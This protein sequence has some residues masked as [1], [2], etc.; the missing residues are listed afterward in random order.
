MHV[1]GTRMHVAGARHAPVTA[2]RFTWRRPD[3][4][5]GI[6]SFLVRIDT[7]SVPGAAQ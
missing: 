3:D 1:A 6:D 2:G 5:E 7:T 4:M